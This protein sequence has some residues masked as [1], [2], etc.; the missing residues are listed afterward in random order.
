LPLQVLHLLALAPPLMLTLPLL[1][2]AVRL[3]LAL[4][5][6]LPAVRPARTPRR[7]CML[8]MHVNRSCGAAGRLRTPRRHC[9]SDACVQR[10]GCAP[11]SYLWA[12]CATLRMSASVSVPLPRLPRARASPRGM[13]G[14]PVRLA[15]RSMTASVASI[16]AESSSIAASPSSVASRPLVSPA[17]RPCSSHHSRYCFVGFV[18]F[19]WMS[20][21][22]IVWFGSTCMHGA[23]LLRF[24]PRIHNA[25]CQQHKHCS[26]C[27]PAAPPSGS[28]ASRTQRTQTFCTPC[29]QGPAGAS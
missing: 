27:A 5:P 11:T 23:R 25:G 26:G 18:G 15:T 29:W 24:P 4:Q 1:P 9:A 21:P 19:T 7:S 22:S 28:L 20:W 13:P 3:K 14:C 16:S 17:A 12:S 2:C 10:L 6:R 8:H